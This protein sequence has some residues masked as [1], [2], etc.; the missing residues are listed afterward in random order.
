MTALPP[1]SSQVVVLTG[2]TSGIGLSTARRL[3]EAGATLILVSRGEADLQRL[4]A[5]I[6]AGGGKA[7]ARPADVADHDEMESIAT[8]AAARFGRLDTWINDA[9]V[10]IYGALED[11]PVEDQ[12]RLFETNYWGVVG[13]SL[14]A[15]RQFKRQGGP[16]KLINVGSVLS[17]RSLIY[18]GTYS[19][20]K[21]AVKGITDALRMELEAAGVPISVTLIKPAAIAT[22]YMEH[23]RN[24]FGSEGNMNPPPSYHPD[25]VAKAIAHACEHDVRDLVVGGGG[26]A[27]SLM[28][29]LAPT[30]T[31]F[32]MQLIGKVVQTSQNPPRPGMRDNLHTSARGGEEVTSNPS[33]GA[34]R[35]S[36]LLEAQMHPGTIAAA[37]LG[38]VGALVL[39]NRRRS[40]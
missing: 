22:P 24:Y 5:E 34:R 7:I 40:H 27:V 39:A 3:A 30:L 33:V 6:E 4:A 32:A 36:L 19:A 10:A 1:L 37:T 28:G 29:T 11:V 2:A 26:A 35:T 8:E 38:L 15:V 21:H 31:D 14:A 23:A 20:S 12:K 16:G 25:L 18:Q 13:G 17:D 9:G